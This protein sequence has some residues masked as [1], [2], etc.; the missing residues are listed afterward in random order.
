VPIPAWIVRILA[1][2][3]MPV[4]MVVTTLGL[5]ACARKPSAD[6]ARPAEQAPKIDDKKK[7]ITTG[8][9]TKKSDDSPLRLTVMERPDPSPDGGTAR[10]KDNKGMIAQ[11]KVVDPAE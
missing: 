2:G 7:R 10:P 6:R 9:S 8:M 1:S 3:F 5:N 11:M 4:L